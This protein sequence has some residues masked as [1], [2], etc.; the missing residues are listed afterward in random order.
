[1]STCLFS[2]KQRRPS[3][4]KCLL[5]SK[6]FFVLFFK[7]FI[8]LFT[9]DTVRQRHRQRERQAPCGEPDVGLYPGTLS[10]HSGITP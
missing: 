1:M 4:N 7:D 10:W 3:E 5:S 2:E 8:Y 9:R 6:D